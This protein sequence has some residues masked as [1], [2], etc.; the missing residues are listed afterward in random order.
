MYINLTLIIELIGTVAFAASGAMVG[1]RKKMDILGICVLALCVAVGG[2]VIRDLL[3]GCT[4]PVTFQNPIYALCAIG[5]AVILFIPK[6]RRFI[7]HHDRSY[8]LGMFWMDSIGLGVFTAMGVQRCFETVPEAGIFL[9]VF[10]GVMTGVG[11]GVLRDVLA[12][13]MP[14][15]FVKHFY[16]S[17]SIIGAIICTLLWELLFPGLCIIICA[18][19]VIILRFFAARY[20]WSLPKAEDIQ[21]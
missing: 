19:I 14:Y 18:G 20:H 21:N 7:A 13:D 16:A 17:A 10:V 8:G 4:P 6:V 9:A 15:I 3:L 1:I 12:G 11:G 5:V 2:G